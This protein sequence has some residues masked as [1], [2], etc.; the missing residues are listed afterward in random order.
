MYKIENKDILENIKEFHLNHVG[1][2]N[3][4]CIRNDEQI[5]TFKLV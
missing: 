2:K 1:I 5:S 4:I 3:F